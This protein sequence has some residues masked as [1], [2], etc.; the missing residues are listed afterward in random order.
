[1]ENGGKGRGQ[2]KGVFLC[3]NFLFFESFHSTDG[4]AP[5]DNE[6][7]AAA[8]AGAPAEAAARKLQQR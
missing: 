3:D 1:M 7:A 2:G 4:K 6:A 8:A 5:R